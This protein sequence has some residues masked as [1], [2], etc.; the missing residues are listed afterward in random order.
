MVIMFGD[1]EHP[2]AR[3]VPPAQHVF[4][5]RNYVFTLLRSPEGE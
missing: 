5:E 1:F 3:H 4:E 2:L